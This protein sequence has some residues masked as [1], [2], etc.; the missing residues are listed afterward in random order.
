MRA[1]ARAVAQL[2]YDWTQAGRPVLEET[3]GSNRAEEQ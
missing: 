3:A 1:V 2:I